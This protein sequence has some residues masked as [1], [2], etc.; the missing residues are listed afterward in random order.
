[1]QTRRQ[2]DYSKTR[3]A[4]QDRVAKEPFQIARPY[5]PRIY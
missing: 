5:P 3:H 2:N 4:E 1:M